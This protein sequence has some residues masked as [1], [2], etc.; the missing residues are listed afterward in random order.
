MAVQNL[1]QRVTRHGSVT[2]IWL[3]TDEDTVVV[4]HGAVHLTFYRKEFEAF[5]DCLAEARQQL[6]GS[7]QPAPAQG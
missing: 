5:V 2:S 6:G 7:R 1:A 4:Q 3:D